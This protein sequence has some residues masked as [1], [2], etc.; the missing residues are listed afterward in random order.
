MPPNTQGLNYERRPSLTS[1]LNSIL[2]RLDR[3]KSQQAQRSG[4]L[5]GWAACSSLTLLVLAAQE[6]ASTTAA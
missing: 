3:S 2:H 5:R 1:W 4:L 6:V